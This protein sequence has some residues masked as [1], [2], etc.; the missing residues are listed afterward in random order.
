M[1]LLKSI[2]V[3]ETL[4]SMGMLNRF[5]GHLRVLLILNDFPLLFLA[6]HKN[7]VFFKFDY[8]EV[9]DWTLL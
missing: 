5:G 4:R 9:F 1:D 3:F 2:S 8:H 6:L 7:D